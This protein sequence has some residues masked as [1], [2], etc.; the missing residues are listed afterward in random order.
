MAIQKEKTYLVFNYC[1][2]PVGV[3]TRTDSFII[4]G[5]EDGVPTSMAF[6]IDE[7]QQ[8]NNNSKVFKTGRLRF[9]ADYEKEIYE[10]LRIHNWESILTNTQI[11]EKILNS[12]TENIKDLTEIE[13]ARYFNRIYGIFIG[14]R[15]AGLDISSKMETALMTRYR[16]LVNPKFKLE[17][18]KADESSVN[19]SQLKSENEAMKEQIAE[20]QK[21]MEQFKS[22]MS[23]Q[24]E[25]VKS[26]QNAEQKAKPTDKS[27]KPTKNKEVK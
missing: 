26:E 12:N 2:S 17:R 21:M 5:A 8:I 11:E 3:A 15:N 13:D 7:L 1:N 27:T 9:E 6:T 19:V 14:L 4:N 25:N 23:N 16:E 18:K 24:T 10:V 20:M 22:M